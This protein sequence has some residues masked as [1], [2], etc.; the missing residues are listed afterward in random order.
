[1]TP[2]VKFL[3]KLM[4]NPSSRAI[5]ELYNFLEHK[6]LPVTENGNFLAYKGLTHDYWSRHNGRVKLLKGR[7]NEN[8]QIFNGVGEEIQIPRNQVDDNKENHCS[9]GLHAGSLEYADG[10]RCGG[11][12]VIVEI[13]PADVVSIPSDCD[14]QKLRT[15]RYKVVGEYEG[16]LTNAYYESNFRTENDDLVDDEFDSFFTDDN[17]EPMVDGGVYIVDE[18][19]YRWD[20]SSN[21][22]I[23]LKD[24][25]NTLS[26]VWAEDASYVDDSV[27][28]DSDGNELEDGELYRNDDGDVY[29]W[30]ETLDH[31]ESVRPNDGS[32]VSYLQS[33][34]MGMVVVD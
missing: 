31:F 23:G 28:L 19:L 18:S 32:T 21:M 33:V 24:S 25:T 22:L 1:M 20:S 34:L 14:G 2:L 6:N 13:D 3:A 11:K 17:D 5:N 26:S 16:A 30:N 12:L 29:R 15:C 4:M 27:R 7:A 10:F 8:G 9:Y